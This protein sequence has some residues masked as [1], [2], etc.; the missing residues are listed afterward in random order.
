[1]AKHL[2]KLFGLLFQPSRRE[3][4]RILQCMLGVDD[5]PLHQT[6]TFALLPRGSPRTTDRALVACRWGA[7]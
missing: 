4:L 3:L 1:M 6:T 5:D 7:D 2:E